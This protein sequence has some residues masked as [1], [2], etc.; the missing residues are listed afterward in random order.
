MLIVCILAFDFSPN[1]EFL[2]IT[3]KDGLLRIVDYTNERLLKNRVIFT[4]G[5][6]S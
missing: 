1:H 4:I 2:A 5:T 3:G 6:Q